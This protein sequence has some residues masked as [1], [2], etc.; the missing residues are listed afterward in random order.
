MPPPVGKTPCVLH[1]IGCYHLGPFGARKT[2]GVFPTGDV[3]ILV[4]AGIFLSFQLGGK[5]MAFSLPATL[6]YWSLR[7]FSY[8]FNCAENAWR[9]PYRG[10]YHIGPCGDFLIVS[11]GRKTHGVF[12]TGD[13][14]ILVPTGIFLSFLLRGKRM[15]FSLQVLLSFC[16]LRHFFSYFVIFGQNSMSNSLLSLIN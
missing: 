4:L 2:H 3:I 5:R 15:A 10:R 16:S 6:S 11:I 8:R 9:F 13:V 12:P 1:N 14:I 7:G